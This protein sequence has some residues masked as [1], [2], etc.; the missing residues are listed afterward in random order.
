MHFFLN[1][2]LFC[3]PGLTDKWLMSIFW[4]MCGVEMHFDSNIGKLLSS[5]GNALTAFAGDVDVADLSSVADAED[6][7]CDAFVEEDADAFDETDTYS[8]TPRYDK[9][10]NKSVL[11]SQRRPYSLER[12][13][14]SQTKVV[15]ELR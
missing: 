3:L 14:W 11:N 7:T 8:R 15:S 9:T 10:A 1:Y 6:D 12:Q 13:L 5:L 2:L 4:R